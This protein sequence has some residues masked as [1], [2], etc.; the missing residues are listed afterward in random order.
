MQTKKAHNNTRLCANYLLRI[1]RQIEQNLQILP[2]AAAVSARCQLVQ[3][4]IVLNGDRVCAECAHAALDA[5]FFLN[6]H[7]HV[8]GVYR[9]RAKQLVHTVV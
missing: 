5:E 8:I 7:F 4:H 2:P 1:L 3:K 9:A 6:H